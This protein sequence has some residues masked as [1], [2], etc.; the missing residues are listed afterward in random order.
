MSLS[1]VCTNLRLKAMQRQIDSA[2]PGP[3]AHVPLLGLVQP[4]SPSARIGTAARS[5]GGSWGDAAPGPADYQDPLRMSTV[6]GAHVEDSRLR[7]VQGAVI[8][9][10]PRGSPTGRGAGG[11]GGPGPADYSYALPRAPGVAFGRDRRDHGGEGGE[12]VPG[13]GAHTVSTGFTREAS[14]RQPMGTAQRFPPPAAEGAPGPG[15]YQAHLVDGITGKSV[16]SARP[17][18]ARALIGTAARPSLGG[19]SLSPGPA[20][21]PSTRHTLPSSPGYSVGRA[22]RD[23]RSAASDSPGPG[24]YAA[25]QHDAATRPASPRQPMGAAPRFPAPPSPDAGEVGPGAYQVQPRARLTGGVIG[26]AARPDLGGPRLGEGPGVAYAHTGASAAVRPRSASTVFGQSR[27]FGAGDAGAGD[28]PSPASYHASLAATLP[29][30][31]RTLIGRAARG[32]GGSGRG[33]GSPGPGAYAVERTDALGALSASSTRVNAPR[34]RIG[35]AARGGSGGGST[36]PGPAYSPNTAYVLP[37][38]AGFA[39]PRSPRD[40]GWKGGEGP[41]PS[42]YGAAD[43][44]GA[45]LPSSPHVRIGTAARFPGEGSDRDA[46]LPGPGAYVVQGCV[47]RLQCAH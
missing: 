8:G 11:E 23:G 36:S 25:E 22:P 44:G 13:P 34:Q 41:G 43:G 16:S 26:T 39:M 42:D 20:Y 32:D 1:G 45:V 33:E 3:S 10:S 40:A 35:S 47:G 9:T 17:Q 24:R 18:S 14:P 2:S 7:A 37:R 46:P 30:P 27:R 6:R 29:S 21:S 19:G 38:A 5:P 31:S 28:A 15:Q 4:K 12:G